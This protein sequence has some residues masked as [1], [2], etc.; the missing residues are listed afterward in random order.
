MSLIDELFDI[1]QEAYRRSPIHALD[2]RIKLILCLLGLVITVLLP[3]G[4]AE[5]FAFLVIYLLFLGLYVLSGSSLRY[6]LMRLLLIMPFGLFFIILQPFF[7]NPYDEVYHVAAT[8]PFGAQ[9]Y[10]ESI[11]FGL[12]LFA[13]FVISLSFIILLSATT[14][15]QAMLEGAAR[16]RIP[17]L[18]V[19]VMGLT[20]R[21]L[22]VFALVYQ[23]IQNAFEVRC[24]SGFDRRLP[25]RYR[26]N[27]IGHAAGSLFVRVLGQGARTYAAMCCRGYSSDSAVY[28]AAKPLHAAEWVFLQIG[29]GYLIVFPIVVYRLF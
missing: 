26:L 10:W 3:Y 6:Y 29:A 15:M 11:I 14:T 4:T 22:Y 18:F 9:M 19:A 2:A 13:K 7:P 27:V 5:L 28:Y 1:E 20:I 21:Y 24:F 12:S 17:W 23:K 8:L 16:L 25:L